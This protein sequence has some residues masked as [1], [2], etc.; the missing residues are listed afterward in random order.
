MNLRKRKRTEEESAGTTELSCPV[1]KLSDNYLPELVANYHPNRKTKLNRS[2]NK[3]LRFKG[4]SH[5]LIVNKCI[6]LNDNTDEI[7]FLKELRKRF[8]PPSSLANITETIELIFKADQGVIR[9]DHHTIRDK[10]SNWLTSIKK[11]LEKTDQG[12][13]CDGV[14]GVITYSEVSAVK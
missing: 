5:D 3:F 13:I 10:G 7:S 8:P 11:L 1:S 9:T 4:P 12:R 6:G 2:S 14:S